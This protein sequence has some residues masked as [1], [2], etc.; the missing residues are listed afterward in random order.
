MIDRF[1]KAMLALQAAATARKLYGVEHAAA[2][3]QVD[4]ATETLSGMLGE[5]AALRLVRLEQSLVFDDVELPSSATLAQALTPRLA[6]HGIEWLEFRRGLER[7]ELVTLLEQLER[8][9]AG[10]AG[11]MRGGA[12]HIKLG[13]VGRRADATIELDRKSVV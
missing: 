9:A 7:A 3:R 5:R 12:A 8:P 4:V 1:D 6:A 2:T 13:Q 10:A 11:V